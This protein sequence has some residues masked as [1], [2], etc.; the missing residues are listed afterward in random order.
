MTNTKPWKSLDLRDIISVAWKRKWLIILPFI[1][2]TAA[3]V[4]GSYQL[5]PEYQSSV[6]VG[7]G[8][9]IMLSD[10]LRGLIGDGRNGI[11]SDRY[12]YEQIQGLQNE[13][14]S[15]LFLKQ[16][17]IR[18]KFDQDPALDRGATGSGIQ[19]DEY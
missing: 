7:L 16:L 10:Q 17:M 13:I 4:V 19:E 2:V 3:A 11:A 12:W 6:I 9:Q 18:L 5:T 8:D 14:K 15:S 1:L